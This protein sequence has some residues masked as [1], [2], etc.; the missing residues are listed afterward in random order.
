MISGSDWLSAE[1]MFTP[2]GT[3]HYY[4]EVRVDPSGL[5]PGTY[6]GMV[7]LTSSIATNPPVDIREHGSIIS[8]PAH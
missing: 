1:K 2:A 6:N 5:D 3:S 7:T 4:I 8:H